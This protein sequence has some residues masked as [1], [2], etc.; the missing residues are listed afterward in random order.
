M[1]KLA[2]KIWKRLRKLR[3]EVNSMKKLKLRQMKMS[4]IFSNRNTQKLHLSYQAAVDGLTLTASMKLKCRVC[5]SSSV[6]NFLTKIQQLIWIIETIS[7]SFIEKALMHI[8]QLQFAER[9]LQVMFAV[10]FAYMP[11]WSTGV[12]STLTFSHT[13]NRLSSL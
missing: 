5:Q 12:S 6:G 2:M 1:N 11:F 7:S 9:I 8:C 4:N 13:L 10:S 3:K